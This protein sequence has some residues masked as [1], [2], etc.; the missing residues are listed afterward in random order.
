MGDEEAKAVVEEVVASDDVVEGKPEDQTDDTA[1]KGDDQD[2][3]DG[4]QD[5][6]DEESEIVLT[7]DAGSQPDNEHRGIRKRINKLNSKVEAAQ[8]GQSQATA[9]LEV[10]RER[11]KLLQ[12]ALEQREQADVKGPPDPDDFD[13]GVA[14]P[15]YIAAAHAHIKEGVIA[16]IKQSQ[17]KGPQPERK[18]TPDLEDKQVKHYQRADKL[19]VKDYD[20][21]ED[22]AIEILGQDIVKQV[23]AATDK[24]AEIL[25][26]L[27]KNPD[28]AESIKELIATNPVQ[29]VFEIGALSRGLEVRPKAQSKPAP[30]PDT[31]LEGG[32]SPKSNDYEKKLDELR[33]K[34]RET[35]DLGPVLAHK[36]KHLEKA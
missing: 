15:K 14:D 20:A 36:K 19:K 28:K 25:Y 31:E 16:E 30:D 9:A 13:D 3:T 35:G 10:E 26:Y 34:A 12:L 5:A 6:A 33:E 7:G 21:T 11:N 27:G 29:G 22:K 8:D 23:M 2:G 17:P 32:S 24:S 4:E 1:L 18:S